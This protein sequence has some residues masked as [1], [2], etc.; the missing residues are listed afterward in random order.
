MTMI[1]KLV[2]DNQWMFQHDN[3]FRLADTIKYNR[4][5]WEHLSI[6]NKI[7]RHDYK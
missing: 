6:N 2:K 1:F 3:L 5:C 4:K 7:W